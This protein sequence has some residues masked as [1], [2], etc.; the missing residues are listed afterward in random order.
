M[1]SRILKETPAECGLSALLE[2]ENGITEIKVKADAGEF[3]IAPKK[4]VL[5]WPL[6]PHLYKFT[7]RLTDGKKCIAGQLHSRHRL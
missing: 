1:C 5:S 7:V 6:K 4:A 3:Y 2:D